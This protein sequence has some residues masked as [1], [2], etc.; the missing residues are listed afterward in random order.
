MAKAEAKAELRDR[1]L[2]QLNKTA[3]SAGAVSKAFLLD[4]Q[5]RWHDIDKNGW[6]GDLFNISD[7]GKAFSREENEEDVANAI[8]DSGS[9]GVSGD[10]IVSV[11]QGDHLAG[12][13]RAFRM[14]H[15]TRIRSDIHSAARRMGHA[16]DKG[17]L[18]R[19]VKGVIENILK[20]SKGSK[21]K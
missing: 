14:R 13:E 20:Q 4:G 1:F 8:V 16:H 10:L 12:Q 6:D 18:K 11:L 2:A 17:L 7:I 15:Q 5:R 9:P 21:P 3:E 19:G